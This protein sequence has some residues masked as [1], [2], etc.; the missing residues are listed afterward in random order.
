VLDWLRPSTDDIALLNFASGTAGEPK[1]VM[2]TANTLG[3]MLGAMIACY[4]LSDGH[5]F[6]MASTM[7][8][9]T[10]S[11][12]WIRLPIYLGAR[13]V[14]QDVWDAAEFIRLVD[15]ERVT[16]TAG[17]TPFRDDTL[18]A[19]NLADHDLRLL[20]T[21]LCVGAPIPR[22]LAKEAAT[23]LECSLRSMFG[24]TEAGPVTTTFPDDSRERAITTDGRLLPQMEVSVRD[25][26]GRGCTPGQEG[27]IYT[28]GACM[29]AG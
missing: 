24:L 11:V 4:E 18:R 8:H 16:F 6:H 28:R 5:V 12:A 17:A 27:D 22:P 25:S 7:G 1:G 29:F 15:A 2:H 26:D 9:V 14:Y 3:A 13:A 19:P 10:G 23:W 20:R 21:F